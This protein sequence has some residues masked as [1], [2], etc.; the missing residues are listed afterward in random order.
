[1]KQ[2]QR[3]KLKIGMKEETKRKSKDR[4]EGTSKEQRKEMYLCFISCLY[5]QKE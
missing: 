3:E 5:H 1:M 4:N 2:R